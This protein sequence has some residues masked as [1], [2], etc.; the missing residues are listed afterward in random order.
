MILAKTKIVGKVEICVK[1]L[2]CSTEKEARSDLDQG[3]K[4]CWSVT[5]ND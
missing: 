4:S 3:K 2:L 1:S 5:Q